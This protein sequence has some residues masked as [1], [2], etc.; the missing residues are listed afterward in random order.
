M[1]AEGETDSMIFAASER[2]GREIKLMIR[3]QFIT[4]VIP[5]RADGE[6]PLEWKMVA[7]TTLCNPLPG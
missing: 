2:T 6:G 7:Q 1:R 5:N 3:F 4:R